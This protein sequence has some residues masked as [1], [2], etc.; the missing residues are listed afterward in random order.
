MMFI[1]LPASHLF[2]LYE[3]Q[4]LGVLF[5]QCGERVAAEP[6]QDSEDQLRSG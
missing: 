4:Q 2:Y 1:A 6:L 3:L 5:Q